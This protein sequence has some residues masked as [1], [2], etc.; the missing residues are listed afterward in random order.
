MGCGPIPCPAFQVPVAGA[1]E[2]SWRPGNRSPHL[3]RH[4]QGV[5]SRAR[6]LSATRAPTKSL[7]AP[8]GAAFAR[9]WSTGGPVRTRP[10]TPL[11]AAGPRGTIGHYPRGVDSPVLPCQ[12]GLTLRRVRCSA[13]LIARGGRTTSKAVWV[14]T[15]RCTVLAARGHP[16]SRDVAS[17]RTGRMRTTTGS[18]HDTRHRGRRGTRHR[19]WVVQARGVKGRLIPR[20]HPSGSKPRRASASAAPQRNT[21]E[22][23][24]LDRRRSWG[25]SASSV[26]RRRVVLDQAPASEG[27]ELR[28]CPSGGAQA[29]GYGP[30]NSTGYPAARFSPPEAVSL[31]TLWS[32]GVGYLVQ[33][34]P[35]S[36]TW[37]RVSRSSPR[38]S[39][40]KAGGLRVSNEIIKRVE[41]ARKRP[42]IRLG[43]V[44]SPGTRDRAPEGSR[45]L[46]RP[47]RFCT[48]GPLLA[49]TVRLVRKTN[50]GAPW[51]HPP[52]PY[53]I[54]FTH[55]AG[56]GP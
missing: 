36:R 29:P 28:A 43:P 38:T 30:R 50:E 8:P 2:S 52:S 33:A 51:P 6:S 18:T 3:C 11:A 35:R 7:P 10:A 37:V 21:G 32:V 15:V 9:A 23:R 42:P 41:I 27:D 53:A 1:L 13:A 14:R 12:R 5:R 20:R 44:W 19:K 25:A 39:R 22:R 49:G 54:R 16:P 47:P 48:C 26:G 55:P 56:W 34:V 45:G 17:P 31:W 46:A 40:A 4:R 24:R